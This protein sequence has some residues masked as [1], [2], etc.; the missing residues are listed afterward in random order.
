MLLHYVC[1]LLL[2]VACVDICPSVHMA[3]VMVKLGALSWD[4]ERA[5]H[6][7]IENV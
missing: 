5:N 3:V 2:S 6:T 7:L 4:Q 1:E